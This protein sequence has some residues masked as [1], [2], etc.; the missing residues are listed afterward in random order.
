MYEKVTK[1]PKHFAAIDLAEKVR[2][3]LSSC[4]LNASL[5]LRPYTIQNNIQ[6]NYK[7]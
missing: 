1:K 6:E 5:E 4:F 2:L 3:T 7:Q